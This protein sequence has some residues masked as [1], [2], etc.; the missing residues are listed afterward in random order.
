MATS[1]SMFDEVY[2]GGQIHEDLRE[3]IITELNTCLYSPS[4]RQHDGEMATH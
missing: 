1:T 3:M 4:S 2:D